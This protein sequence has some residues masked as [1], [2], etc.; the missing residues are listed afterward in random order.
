MSEEINANNII[1]ED[2]SYIIN[3]LLLQNKKYGNILSVLNKIKIFISIIFFIILYLISVV[4]SIYTVDT[5]LRLVLQLIFLFLNIFG[6]L[7]IFKIYDIQ[8]FCQNKNLVCACINEHKRITIYD[9][10]TK[11]I[12]KSYWLKL[13]NITPE[14][15]LFFTNNKERDTIDLYK[16]MNASEYILNLIS[17]KELK[18]LLNEINN[19]EVV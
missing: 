10:I 14:T 2:V 17:K 5:T 1:N 12:T 8:Y 19:S 9:L 18:K 16:T 4:F 13:K 11:L 7:K 3:E 15:T 6:N